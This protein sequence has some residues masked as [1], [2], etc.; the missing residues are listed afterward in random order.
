MP[1]E[2]AWTF[3]TFFSSVYTEDDHRPV[4]FLPSCSDAKMED[5]VATSKAVEHMLNRLP[6]NSAPGPDGI[7]PVMVPILARVLAEPLARL[8]Y[9][10]IKA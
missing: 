1:R 2:A 8:V 9:T 10:T 3:R 5:I 7:H 4:G 6:P